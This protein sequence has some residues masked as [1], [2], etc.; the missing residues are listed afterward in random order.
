MKEILITS[1]TLNVY[2]ETFYSA[3]SNWHKYFNN[4]KV[5]NIPNEVSLLDNYLK[6]S[7]PKLIVLTGGG[8]VKSNYL[9]KD[10]FD[11][12]RE[13]VE[14]RLIDHCIKNDISIIG[15]CRGMQKILSYLNSEIEFV[16]ND[17]EIKSKYEL[18]NLNNQK[19]SPSGFRTCFNNFSISNSKNIENNWDIINLDS[20][21][22]LLSVKNKRNKILCL[23]WHPERD[24]TDSKFIHSF[25]K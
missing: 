19:Y 16:Q 13:Q 11:E 10:D 3:D 6:Y 2:D 8:N 23:M 1:K 25:L 12:N 24:N 15:V 20:N 9:A 22:N 4:Y 7:K 17:Y 5:L 21:N 14:E 18:K